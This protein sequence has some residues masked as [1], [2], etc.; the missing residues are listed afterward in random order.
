MVVGSLHMIGSVL[1][2]L[3]VRDRWHLD[4]ESGGALLG[5]V[6]YPTNSEPKEQTR[7]QQVKQHKEISQERERQRERERERERERDRGG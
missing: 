5:L 1:V 4:L 2:Q 6:G 7:K 3:R